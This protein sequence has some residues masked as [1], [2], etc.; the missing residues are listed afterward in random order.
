MLVCSECKQII[1]GEVGESPHGNPIHLGG[2]PDDMVF[3]A[4]LEPFGARVTVDRKAVDLSNQQMDAIQRLATACYSMNV[5]ID[6]DHIHKMWP[7]D[8]SELA[9]S[10]PRPSQGRISFYMTTNAFIHDMAKRGVRLDE[11]EMQ[12]TSEQIALIQMMRNPEGRKLSTILKR[13]GV[14]KYKFDSWMKQP[15]FQKYITAQ[16]GDSTTQALLLSEIS[17]AEKAQDGD[18]NAIKFLM[19]WQGKYNPHKDNNAADVMEFVRIVLGVVQRVV[20]AMPNGSEALE[21]IQS[22]IN[23]QRSTMGIGNN[24]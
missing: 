16:I 23:L 1:T 3:S 21:K 12:L 20:G 13:A 19:E 2:C 8:T 7:T 4:D 22:E 9:L 18:L 10:G 6:A 11:M 15:L 17:L 24:N 5:K 14:T